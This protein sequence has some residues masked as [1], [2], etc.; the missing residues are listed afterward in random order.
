MSPELKGASSDPSTAKKQY[1]PAP[2]HK[3]RMQQL[4]A[5]IMGCRHWSHL[6]RLWHDNH[7][8][9]NPIHLCATSVKLSRLVTD[10][11]VHPS[12]RPEL[13]KFADAMQVRI[14]QS[15]AIARCQ[16][17]SYGIGLV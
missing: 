13:F 6:Q 14:W 4:T 16:D 1:I 11:G 8:D 10:Q 2:T 9:L 7:K 15:K 12:D 5:A 3:G 17:S